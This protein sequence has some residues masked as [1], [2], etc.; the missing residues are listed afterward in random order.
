MNIKDEDLPTL[1]PIPEGSC[2]VIV[3][4]VMVY[5]VKEEITTEEDAY[6]TDQLRQAQRDAYKLAHDRQ[7]VIIDRLINEKGII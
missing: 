6:S 1:P 2:S 7:Q 3:G 4:H 5:G